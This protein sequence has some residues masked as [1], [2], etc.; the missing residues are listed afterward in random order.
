MKL[1]E[2]CYDSQVSLEQSLLR[3]R[4]G[5]NYRDESLTLKEVSQLLWA[6]QGITDAVGLRTAP[7]AGALYPLEV[8]P[9]VGNVIGISPGIYRYQ[10]QGH[11]LILIVAGDKR[12]GLAGA[13]L[14]Q[15]FIRE[16]AVTFVFAAVYE[17]TTS[18][19]GE[20]GIRYV[21]LEAGHAAQNLCLEATAGELGVV[22][23]G[24]FNDDLVAKLLDLPEKETPLYLITVGKK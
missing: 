14:G 21:H 17:R 13:A 20:R 18:K 7:S 16:G 4:S 22:T 23:V 5:R 1:P 9:V 19:Y 8:Y 10:P 6:A 11:E 24:A 12:D 2:P 3:R 15:G